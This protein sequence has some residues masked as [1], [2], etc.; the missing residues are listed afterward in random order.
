[1]ISTAG[2]TGITLYAP[3]ELIISGARRHAAA[4]DRST[5][6]EHGANT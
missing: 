4:R 5:V 2:L 6:A 1:M 3:K